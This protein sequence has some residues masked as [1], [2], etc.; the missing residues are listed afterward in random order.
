MMRA[1]VSRIDKADLK[2]II[3][4]TLYLLF[5]ALAG[6]GLLLAFRMPHGGGSGDGL[7]LG[8]RRHT[9]GEVHTWLAYA[10]LAVVTFHL[11]LNWQ[12]LVKVAAS[13]HLWRLAVGFVAGLLIVSVF[14][15]IPTQP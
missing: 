12:W 11:M 3:D 15:F 4:L 9:W 14:L 2:R 6:T 8:L 10:T 5:C 13:K 7:F 1:A